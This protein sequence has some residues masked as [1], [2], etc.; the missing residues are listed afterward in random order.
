MKT[1]TSDLKHQ[2]YK[3]HGESLAKAL[4]RMYGK[5]TIGDSAAVWLKV[6]RWP[7]KK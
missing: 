7:E 6:V 3:K 4:A 2:A 5:Q 1:P